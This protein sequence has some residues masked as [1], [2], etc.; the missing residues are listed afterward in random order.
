M[1]HDVSTMRSRYLLTL[2]TILDH[3]HDVSS[4]TKCIV[5]ARRSILCEDRACVSDCEV[6]RRWL[7]EREIDSLRH[8]VSG[9]PS[10]L[11]PVSF[12]GKLISFLK[13]ARHASAARRNAREYVPH[14]CVSSSHEM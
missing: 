9:T 12:C 1:C 4:G 3:T 7:D 10:T 14:T 2:W 13:G 11:F 8:A 6:F 5:C